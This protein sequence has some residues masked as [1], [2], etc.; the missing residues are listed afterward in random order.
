MFSSQTMTFKY[1]FSTRMTAGDYQPLYVAPA[2]EGVKLEH[3]LKLSITRCYLGMELE[4]TV[5]IGLPITSHWQCN[6]PMH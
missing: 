4:A 1:L 6:L 5:G 2:A 3:R